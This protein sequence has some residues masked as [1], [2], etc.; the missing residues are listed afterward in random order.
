MDRFDGAEIDRDAG[1]EHDGGA[2]IA[3]GNDFGD[4]RPF[5][6]RVD[7]CGGVVTGGDG[8]EIAHGFAA[9]APASG[10][11][12]FDHAGEGAQVILQ[13][14]S[15]G[16]DVGDEAAGFL[17]AAALDRLG[18][19]VLQLGA[20]AGD[21]CEAILGD[22]TLQIVD[23]LDA[24]LVVQRA[25]AFGAEAGDA[26]DAAHA[27]VDLLLDGFQLGSLAVLHQCGDGSREIGADAGE[28]G[29]VVAVGHHVAQGAGLVLDGVGGGAVG[30]H[31]ERVGAA[32]DFQ[33][34]GHLAKG[35]GDFGVG[36]GHGGVLIP[37]SCKAPGRGL[38]SNPW[39]SWQ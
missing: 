37:T 7:G 24:E 13:L 15:D 28:G 34:V 21:A 35:F 1:M 32:G 14:L 27:G 33:K 4:G 22:G 39:A 38:E 25:H 9:A 12:G 16:I 36:H 20:E 5:G 17:G 19:L 3:V 26:H 11:V 23:V 31:A 6:E 2:G 29:Q 30:A 18:N 10:D 8:I